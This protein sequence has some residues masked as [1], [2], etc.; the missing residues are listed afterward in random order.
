MA[1]RYTSDMPFALE[2]ALLVGSVFLWIVASGFG[3]TA[4]RL[5]ISRRKGRFR[6]L[7]QGLFGLGL[8]AMVVA[9]LVAS[10]KGRHYSVDGYIKQARV[11][12]SGRHQRTDV[13]LR[14]GSSPGILVLH[15]EGAN[16][17]FRP[18][19]HVILT[20]QEYSGSILKARF[21]TASGKQEGGYNNADLLAPS[22]CML[23]AFF[24]IWNAVRI[25]RRDPEGAE[26][27]REREVP[28][29]SVDGDSLLHL[30]R[31]R[32]D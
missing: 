22:L 3:V 13:W 8:C 27:N 14:A 4:Y 9:V 24:I 15:A 29:N 18:G 21:F 12:G 23:A 19:E 26:E 2:K 17:L 20:Y 25:Y 7:A 31:D 16:P 6:A 5:E 28:L 11:S 30:S 32:P 10:Y 1:A